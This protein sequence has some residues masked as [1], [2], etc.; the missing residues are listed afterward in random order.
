M[1]IPLS[2]LSQAEPKHGRAAIGDGEGAPVG[3]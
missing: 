2:L 1:I 3:G